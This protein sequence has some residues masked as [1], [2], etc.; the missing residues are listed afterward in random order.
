MIFAQIEKHSP[1]CKGYAH[2]HRHLDPDMYPFSVYKGTV[3]TVQ[4]LYEEFI[5]HPE[6]FQM[7]TRYRII[8]DLDVTIWRAPYGI[9]VIHEVED[10]SLARPVHDMEFRQS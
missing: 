2:F 9:D 6:Y 7:I 8:H 4:V 1:H 5:L 3:F 10:L